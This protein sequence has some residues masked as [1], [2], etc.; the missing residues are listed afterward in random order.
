[1]ELGRELPTGQSS[2][3]I[4]AVELTR[5]PTDPVLPGTSDAAPEGSLT[6][7]KN[8][9]DADAGTTECETGHDL[10][11]YQA[12]NV[13]LLFEGGEPDLAQTRLATAIQDMGN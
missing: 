9:S 6:V 7:Y 12:G 3:K 1:L 13:G 5:K 11:C 8:T 10:L 4:Y 2:K